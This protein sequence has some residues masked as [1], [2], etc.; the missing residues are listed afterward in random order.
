MLLHANPFTEQRF[1]GLTRGPYGH[2]SAIPIVTE[3]QFN[4][5]THTQFRTDHLCAINEAVLG[6]TP[7]V[8][9]EVV[10][11]RDHLSQG[12]IPLEQIFYEFPASCNSALTSLSSAGALS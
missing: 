1:E 9:K 7:V 6:T 4:R 10:V 3:L 8:I 2:V 11:D 5:I 12:V